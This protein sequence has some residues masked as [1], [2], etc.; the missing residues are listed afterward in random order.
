MTLQKGYRQ[1]SGGV[2]VQEGEMFDNWLDLFGDG[3]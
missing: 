3:E 2:S 1:Y